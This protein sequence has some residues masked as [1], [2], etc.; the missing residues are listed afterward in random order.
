[1][2]GKE[3]ETVREKF[4]FLVKESRNKKQLQLLINKHHLNLIIALNIGFVNYLLQKK[5]KLSK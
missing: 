2:F 4:A 3:T 5:C 1:M